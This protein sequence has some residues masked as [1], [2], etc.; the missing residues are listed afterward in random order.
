MAGFF[1][2]NWA[3]I[4]LSAMM[5]LLVTLLFDTSRPV[6][7]V[8]VLSVPSGAE[9]SDGEGFCWIAP[10][11]IP[12]KHDGLSITLTYPGRVPVDT[13]LVPDMSGEKVI[14]H[15]P[16]RFSVDL[17][18]E[19]SGASIQLDGSFRGYTPTRVFL[20]SPGIH[21]VILVVDELIVLEDSFSLLSNV[22]RSFHRVLPEQ[23]SD[24]LILVPSG[25]A[26]TV[27]LSSIN[28]PVDTLAAYLISRYEVTNTEFL[29]YLSELEFSPRKDT[30]NRWGRTDTIE[31]IFQGDYPIPFYISPSGRWAIRDGLEEY[32]V[33][34]LSFKAAEAYCTWLS[35]NDTLGLSYRLPEEEE[36]FAAAIAG[37]SGPWPWGSRRPDGSLLN[38]SDSNEELLGRHPS[39]DDGFTHAAPVGSFP[40][41]AWG[42]YDIAGNVWE[43]CQPVHPDSSPVVRG[44]SWLSSMEDCECKARMRPE[45]GLGYPYI[46]LRIAAS[47]ND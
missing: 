13:I 34:G 46:G 12:V 28:E 24:D 5:I 41:N 10:V 31:E 19:P 11:R 29:Q 8:Q 45:P 2:R 42:L 39:I 38:L 6:A 22:P 37:G 47:F 16:Y 23:Y 3:V 43:W 36:W 20:D 14:I 33:S 9:V 27:R 35:S 44:G 30:S 25:A 26:G 15:L 40:A 32:P 7:Y 4:L 21:Q 17:S 18:S 1:L